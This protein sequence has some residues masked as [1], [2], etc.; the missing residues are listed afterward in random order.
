MQVFFQCSWLCSFHGMESRARSSVRWVDTIGWCDPR[1]LRPLNLLLEPRAPQRCGFC[2]RVD[3]ITFLSPPPPRRL[4]SS[5]SL[6][7]TVSFI[8]LLLAPG[9]C[10]HSRLRQSAEIVMITRS[11][12]SWCTARA[13]TC[14]ARERAVNGRYE[15]KRRRK[16]REYGGRHALAMGQNFP[17]SDRD[18][19]ARNSEAVLEEAEHRFHNT[20]AWR[21]KGGRKR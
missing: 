9:L 18:Y 11:L 3:F 6:P 17:R 13:P 7:T 12:I 19:R 20:L 1:L 5:P 8:V 10:T 16:R 2:G 21:V 4:G 14:S 15:T